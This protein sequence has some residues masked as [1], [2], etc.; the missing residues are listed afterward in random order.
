MPP[1]A[2]AQQLIAYYTA[3]LPPMY[4]KPKAQGTIAALAGGSDGQHGL[5]GNAIALQ[6]RSAFDLGGLNG[7]VP[8]AGQQLDFL[9]ELIGPSRYLNGLVVPANYTSLPTYAQVVSGQWYGYTT[10]ELPQPP[11]WQTFTYE[12][13]TANTLPDGQYRQ[14]LQFMAQVNAAWFSYGNIDQLLYDFMG[15]YVNLVVGPQTWTYQHLTSDPGTLFEI[16][17][18]MNLLPCPAGV[19]LSVAEVGAF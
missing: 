7:N 2:A 6:V 11:T 12:D 19:T 14:L 16:L 9:G 5:I 1:T 13:L 3:L 10:Y 15:A 4:Q 18:Q 17:K 8:A